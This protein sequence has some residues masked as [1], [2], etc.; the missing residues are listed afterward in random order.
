MRG[1]LLLAA[2]LLFSTIVLPAHASGPVGP[3]I[4]GPTNI[5]AARNWTYSGQL[6]VEATGSPAP[7][8]GQ[9]IGLYVDG[10]RV[11]EGETDAQGKY[12]ILVTFALGTHAVQ[13]RAFEG[14]PMEEGSPVL[15]VR[16][17]P[18][19][20]AGPALLDGAPGFYYTEA[21]VSWLYPWTDG[22]YPVTSYRIERSANG[23][24]FQ[25]VFTGNAFG[26]VDTNVTP[27]VHYIYEGYSTTAWGTSNKTGG[28][29]TANDTVALVQL[30][31][32][33]VCDDAACATVPDGG[34]FTTNASANVTVDAVNVDGI[35]DTWPVGGPGVA[36]R[37]VYGEL[38]F[39][40]RT[41]EFENVSGPAGAWAHS[42][43]PFHAQAPA[44]S[45]CATVA[46]I[47]YARPAAQGRSQDSGGFDLCV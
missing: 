45:G 32:Y 26:F 11:S 24:P 12:L 38:A 16:A 25:V 46:V 43:G 22:G 34:S 39:P 30:V 36:G 23:G 2:A 44:A 31:S 15:T 33:H 13:T 8:Y 5:P 7:L 1:A 9:T 17:Y 21:N 47:A 41:R 20:P 3:T 14:S 35:V 19:Y 37:R 27:G 6:V 18:T 4:F 29:Y 28:G 10:V 42:I 40:N